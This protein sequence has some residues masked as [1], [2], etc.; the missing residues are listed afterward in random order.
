MDAKAFE[1]EL[2][3]NS[4]ALHNECFLNRFILPLIAKIGERWHTGSLRI[5]QEHFASAI[6]KTFLCSMRLAFNVAPNSP[7]I[8]ITTPSGEAHELGA[9]IASVIA[10]SDGWDVTY[11]GANLPADEIAMAAKSRRAKAVGLSVVN[12]E[13]GADII[14]EFQRLKNSLAPNTTV[15]VGGQGL[16]KIRLL[17]Q[18]IGAVPVEDLK[19]FKTKLQLLA[20]KPD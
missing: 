6:L 1:N 9:I 20:Q 11:L 8:V 10:A 13:M 14:S 16:E 15:F 7:G 17:V 12:S 18:N 4:I 3:R 19:D 2:L 5:A